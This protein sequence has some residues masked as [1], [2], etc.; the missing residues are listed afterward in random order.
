MEFAAFGMD[1]QYDRTLVYGL[2]PDFN[3][4]QIIGVQM[5]QRTDYLANFR[6]IVTQPGIPNTRYCF[7]PCMLEQISTIPD[8]RQTENNV[9]INIIATPIGAS[10]SNEKQIKQI[11]NFEMTTES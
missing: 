6:Y 4:L 2:C 8:K 1:P 11:P 7:P 5:D 9:N 10:I 3:R